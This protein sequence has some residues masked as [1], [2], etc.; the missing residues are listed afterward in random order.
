MLEMATLVGGPGN[1]AEEDGE[2]RESVDFLNDHSIRLLSLSSACGSFK[3]FFLF[4][5]HVY[6]PRLN[7]SYI[8]ATFQ[9]NIKYF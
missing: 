7:S 8:P 4:Q 1:S 2:K 9:L 3:Y 6:W 5:L